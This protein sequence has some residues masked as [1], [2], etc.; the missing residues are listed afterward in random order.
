MIF[1]F[2]VQSGCRD[3][4]REPEPLS[5]S[6]HVQAVLQKCATTPLEIFGI[7]YRA[8]ATSAYLLWL[9]AL[10]AFSTAAVQSA[11]PPDKP[12]F[13]HAVVAADHPLAS[14]A[15]LEILK[16]G[17]NVVDAAVATGFALAVV[18]PAS[19]G[20]GGGGFMLVWDA[21]KKQATAIDYRETAPAGATRA[22]Y[23][24]PANP[25]RVR[26]DLS[27]FGHLSV[28]VPAHVAGLCLAL[29]KHG[30]LDLPT[31]LRPALRL[32]QEGFEIDPHD[33]EVQAEVLDEFRQ[34]PEFEE[35]FSTLLKLYF[36]A[37]R[38]WKSREVFK[39]PLKP[40]LERIAAKGADGYYR[41]PVAEAIVAEMRRGGGLITLEDLAA[42]K[43]KIRVALTTQVQG[44][45]GTFE[46]FT[47]PLPSSGGVA[48]IEILQILGACDRR[49]P[50]SGLSNSPVHRSLR[51][52]VLTEAFKH[53]FADRAASLGDADF[54]DVP[55]RRLVSPDYAMRLAGRVDPTRT[56]PAEKYGRMGGRDDGGTSHF[57]IIDAAGNAVACTETI[58]TAF[59]SL[60]VEPRF[61][62]I[63]NNEMDDFTAHPDIPN[64]FGLKQSSANAIEPGK[65]PLS[66][67]TPTILVREGRATYALGGSGGPRI[68]TATTQ[69]LLHLTRDR[70]SPEQAVLAPRLHHQWLPDRIELER[71]FDPAI[72]KQLEAFGHDIRL[73]DE[74]AV[75]QAVAR[76][77]DGLRGASD[78]R[79]HGKAAGY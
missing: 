27:R 56:Q 10:G 65:R 60:V 12:V 54:A 25:A 68:I 64:A 48:L 55:V 76:S 35:R 62:I 69:V 26:E 31:I 23:V 77:A 61:G 1:P 73:I 28:A 70:L 59:G 7:R 6:L 33:R 51:P 45:F 41:G 53:A 78:P 16:Q 29:E 5:D 19:C 39:S 34:H 14:Q 47:M 42:V 36:N 17:G 67:M 75:V 72:D 21:A 38:S 3:P 44:D 50:G 63:L 57:S 9:T 79:K 49:W 15:G 20:I 13:Q 58:N 71:G 74:N 2:R 66:S 4:R 46:L 40:V 30:T 8:P 11:E 24:D 43:P 37:G 22:M 32:C 52:H 18:R